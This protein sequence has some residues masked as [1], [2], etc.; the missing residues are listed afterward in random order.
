MTAIEKLQTKIEE[1]EKELEE[2]SDGGAGTEASKDEKELEES[3]DGR[4]ETEVNSSEI[5]Q[6]NAQAEGINGT[7]LKR[8]APDGCFTDSMRK[9]SDSGDESIDLSAEV[10]SDANG[11]PSSPLHLDQVNESS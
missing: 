10:P 4:A 2:Y 7:S 9:K 11:S 6:L 1:D 5:A 3:G 8:K